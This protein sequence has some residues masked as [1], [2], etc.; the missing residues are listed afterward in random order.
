MSARFTSARHV[1]TFGVALLLPWMAF[2]QSAALPTGP[3]DAV[4]IRSTVESLS[5]VIAREY[6]DPAVAQKISTMLHSRLSAGAYSDARDSGTLAA[7]LTADLQAESHDKHLAVG[8]VRI[9]R[10]DTGRPPAESRQDA[11]RRTNGGVQR[12]EILSGNVGFLNLTAF[13]RIEEAKESISTAMRLLANADALIFD[14]RDNS[15]GSPDTVAFLIS[16]LLNGRS[17]PLF[18]ITPRYGT[19]TRY[20]SS[21]VAA[22]NGQRPVYVL[23]AARSFSAAEGFSFLLQDFKRAEVIGEMTAGAAN[24]GKPYPINEVFQVVVPNGQLLTAVSRKNWEGSGVTP[25]VPVPAATALRV[26]HER[27]LRRLL[28]T[29]AS[30]GMRG[31]LEAALRE[32]Q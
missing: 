24:P 8:V 4:T 3:L 11:V 19:P 28:D 20:A 30:D 21:R 25:D 13:W 2:A 26:A 12:V 1:L 15:G 9:D 17:T 31:R 14:M 10:T 22:A 18:D 29:A 5:A 23:T 6:F 32:L 27:A 16:F 7:K